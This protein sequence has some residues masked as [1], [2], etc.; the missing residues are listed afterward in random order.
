MVV[1]RI[2]TAFYNNSY[3]NQGYSDG[4]AK[5]NNGVVEYLYHNHTSD[6][7]YKCTVTQT[8]SYYEE[9][10]VLRKQNHSSCGI[11]TSTAV[12]A[13]GADGAYNSSWTHSVYTCG[14]TTSSIEGVKITYN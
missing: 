13:N 3:Y 6:C 14:K 4:Y 1:I 10:Y 9:G 5:E 12:L 7:S 2:N 11:G 8:I